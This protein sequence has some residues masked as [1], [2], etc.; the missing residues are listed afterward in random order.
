[1]KHHLGKLFRAKWKMICQKEPIRA[2]PTG[3]VQDNCSSCMILRDK[4]PVST[5]QSTFGAL[6]P[7]LNVRN[8]AIIAA[9]NRNSNLAV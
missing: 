3:I 2:E 8:Y 4:H 6:H 9:V 1:M 5:L 7:G